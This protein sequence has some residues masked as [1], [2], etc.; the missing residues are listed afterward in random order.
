MYE[1][2]LNLDSVFCANLSFGLED[3]L[4]RITLSDDVCVFGR[5]FRRQSFDI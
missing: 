5:R 2:L 4:F 3:M 1:H